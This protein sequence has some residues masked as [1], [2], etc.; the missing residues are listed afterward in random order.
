MNLSL[1]VDSDKLLRKSEE[2]YHHNIRL[3][4]VVGLSIQFIPLGKIKGSL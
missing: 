2:N 4:K 1:L 3:C